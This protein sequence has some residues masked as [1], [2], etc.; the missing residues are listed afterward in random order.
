MGEPV[1]HVTAQS[2]GAMTTQNARLERQ[3]GSWLFRQFYP[4]YVNE[5]AF[6]NSI[7]REYLPND[8]IVVDAG[9]GSGE[10]S[11]LV[12]GNSNHVVGID[13]EEDLAENVQVTWRVRG[14]LERIPLRAG[15]AD[16]VVCKYVV[17]HLAHPRVAFREF[18]RVLRP[19]GY[20]LIHTPN[21]W[22]YAQWFAWL[23]PQRFHPR[24]IRALCGRSSFPKYRRANTPSA[25]VGAM[26]AAGLVLCRLEFFESAPD[27][28]Q[29]WSPLYL[30]GILYERLVNSTPRLQKW[31]L[32]MVGVFQKP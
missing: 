5:D 14:D 26:R 27:Y 17:E 4:N 28:L 29:R 19:G 32:N 20:V 12:Y 31:R 23:I 6:F 8:G 11:S 16:L 7:L 1:A 24:L 3:R 2:S 10:I 25:L 21:Q 15:A 30:L 13:R 9:C 18:S 22:H